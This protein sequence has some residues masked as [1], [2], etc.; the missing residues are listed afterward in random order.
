LKPTG[1]LASLSKPT[2]AG[3]KSGGIRIKQAK[4]PQELEKENGRLK[5]L[6]ADISLAQTAQP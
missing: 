1:S 2:I 6:G 3:V 5:K 4:S